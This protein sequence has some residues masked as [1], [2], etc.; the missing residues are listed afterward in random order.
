[1]ILLTDFP[2]ADG[3]FTLE[4]FWK[5]RVR[6]IYKADYTELNYYKKWY[7]GVELYSVA[8]FMLLLLWMITLIFLYKHKQL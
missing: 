3:G 4:K 6:Y 7:V 1:M 2:H 8:K 5:L